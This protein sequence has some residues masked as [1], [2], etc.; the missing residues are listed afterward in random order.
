MQLPVQITFRNMPAS[1]VLEDHIHEKAAKLDQ[2]YD[3]IMGCHVVVE[4]PHQHHRQG[5]L[6]HVRIEMILPGGELIVNRDPA[7]KHSHEDVYVAIRD[8]FDAAKRQLQDYVR[9][10]Y[11]QT[12]VHEPT[13]DIA[14][15]SK[16]F[17]ME[18]YG[19]LETP[20][21]KEVYFHRNS[22]L[23]DA[24]DRLE[25]GSQVSFCEESGEKGP[26]ASTV[27]PAKP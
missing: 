14:I 13:Q 17:P 21:G 22:V 27:R 26:Q 3:R 5:K 4:A 9:R 16:L 23:D 12:R 10:H 7:Q 18:D 2:F 8:S 11:T 6:F 24:F 20:D 15:V 1:T 25:I 19:F